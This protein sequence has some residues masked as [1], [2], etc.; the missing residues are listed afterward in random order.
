MKGVDVEA[1]LT[2]ICLVEACRPE[3]IKC[4]N[5]S[6]FN[7]KEMDFGAYSNGVMFAF[8]RPQKTN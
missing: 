6:E 5:G 1:E 2:R 7:S 4:D 8:S 3:R